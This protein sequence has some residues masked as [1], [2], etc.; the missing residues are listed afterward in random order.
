MKVG[1]HQFSKQ[2]LSDFE[3]IY[4]KILIHNHIES[5]RLHASQPDFWKK[6]ESIDFFLSRWLDT[7]D[8]HQLGHTIL[9]IIEKDFKK[10][11]LP[12]YHTYW[13]YDDKIKQF[14]QLKAHGFPAIDSYVFWDKQS[15]LSWMDST[16]L[17][18]IFKLKGGAS[19]SNVIMIKSRNRGKKLIKKIFGSGFI[20]GKI[21]DKGHVKYQDFDIGKKIRHWG[22]NLLKT[23]NGEDINFRW[24]L[25]K[26]YALFQKFMPDN[27]FDT[28]VVVIGG[29]AF[30]FRRFNRENDFRASGSKKLDLEPA[31]IDLR[32][33]K[34]AQQVSRTLNYQCM[35]YD[36]LY[37]EH[38]EPVICE[39]SYTHGQSVIKCPGYWDEEMNWHEGHYWPQYWHLVDLLGMPELIQPDI[40]IEEKSLNQKFFNIINK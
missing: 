12:N 23:L 26:N 4:E 30:A 18:V 17:P 14:F 15:A 32:C 5:I 16:E 2:K 7:S 37:D 19:S 25:H 24:Q 28:R 33:I 35:A 10:G 39:I 3:E 9:P 29:R 21:P 8:H 20:S 22:G 13:H 36:F 6:I 27:T 1:I 34:L 31:N 38:N 11:C 40:T